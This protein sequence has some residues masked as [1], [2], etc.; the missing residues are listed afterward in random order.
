MNAQSLYAFYGTLRKGM[1]HNAL[2]A[3]SEYL[4]TVALQGYKLYSLI[5]YP[6]AVKTE[7][8]DDKI[9]AELF[10]VPD[11]NIQHQ[12]HHLELEAGYFYD[13]I[14][15]EEKSFG[16]YLF[17]EPLHG[18]QVIAEGDWAIYTL[19]SQL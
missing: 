10:Y 6:Y 16:I 5:E 17:Q 8:A 13:E 4:Q 15:V 9:I 12:I 7:C 1:Y 19:Q 3:G 11:Q 2:L 18:N 14:K